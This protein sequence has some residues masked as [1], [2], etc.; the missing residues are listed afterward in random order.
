MY[1]IRTRRCRIIGTCLY[2]VLNHFWKTAWFGTVNEN[3]SCDRDKLK[4]DLDY[5][6]FLTALLGLDLMCFKQ[7]KAVV[8]NLRYLCSQGVRNHKPGGMRHAGQFNAIVMRD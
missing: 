7:I 8:L 5:L 6:F 2:I 1:S 4:T 3:D